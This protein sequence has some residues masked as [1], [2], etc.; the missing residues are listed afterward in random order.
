[1][2][3]QSD[4]PAT[5]VGTENPVQRG[6]ADPEIVRRLTALIRAGLGREAAGQRRQR[7]AIVEEALSEVAYRALATASRF[8]P[9]VG[10]VLHWLGGI[11]WNVLRER[12]KPRR[13]TMLHLEAPTPDP[14]RAVSDAVIDRLEASRILA[15][16][17]ENARQL[18]VW[19]SE[20]WTADE[21]GTE[22]GIKPATARV[23]LHRARMLARELSG[24][25]TG[26]ADHA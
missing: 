22:L 21:M 6:L 18:L 14:R 12:R 8:D 25:G 15:K 13:V 1:M 2:S 23:R 24:L 11:A 4:T 17:P 9:A 5:V 26:G 16:L 10:S 19:E 20:G 7:E 3:G